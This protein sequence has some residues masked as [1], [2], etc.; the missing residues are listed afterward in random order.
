MEQYVKD[1]EAGLNEDPFKFGKL[2]DYS[3]VYSFTFIFGT[4]W[5]AYEVSVPKWHHGG[6]YEY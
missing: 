1:S 6:A 2:D 4:D 5:S 3:H